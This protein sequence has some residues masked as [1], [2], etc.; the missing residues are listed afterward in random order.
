MIYYPKTYGT[1][2]G[3]NK[4]INLAYK[5][6]KEHTDKNVV[7]YKEILHNPYVIKELKKDNIICID[8]LEKINKDD[9]VIIRAHGETLDTFKYLEDNNI[10]YYDATCINVK[11]VHDIVKEKYNENYKIIIVG[12]K[13]H[14]EVIGTASRCNNEAIIIETE[15]DYK[16]INKDDNYF[17][18]CQTT[19]GYETV[20]SLLNYLNINNIKYEHKNTICPHQKLIQSSSVSLSDQMD[21]MFIIGGKHSSN[22]RELYNQCKKICAKSYH[23]D[24]INEFYEIIKKEDLSYTTKIGITAGGSTPKNQIQEFEGL[25]EF[26]IYYKNKTKEL[27]KELT[28]YNKT[29]INE[30]DNKIIKEAINKFINMNS[31]GKFL[32]GCLIDLG[33]KL[34][35]ND[36]YANHLAIAYETFQTSI[37]V[38]DDIIDNAPLRRGKQTIHESYKEEFN[39]FNH[40][41]NIHNNL[42]LCIGDIGFFFTNDLIIKKY[43][44]D[45]NFIKLFNYYN[46][47]VINTI[48]GEILDVYLPFKEKYDKTNKITENDILKIYKLKTSHYSIVGPFILGMI[49]SNSSAKLIKEMEQILEN[50]GI[51]FQI[52]DDILGIFSSKEIL[53]KSVYSDIEEFKQT[54]LYSYIKINKPEYLDKLLEYYGKENICEEDAKCV[55]NIIIESGS[56]DYANNLMNNL[57]IDSKDKINNLDITPHIK[58]ILLGLITYLEIREK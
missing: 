3:A 12:K 21:I 47:I 56:L 26:A 50:I 34:N 17:V 28:K 25:L 41:E 54:I 38:H 22:T 36:D 4:A 20:S 23:V 13:T 48:K 42:S 51:A 7:I 46:Q 44:N 14:P 31:N 30:N 8:D 29:L 6:K 18:V 53:G 45:K 39:N 16:Q 19:I 33:Y 15:D 37:L 10:E 9:I 40:N 49:L 35:K 55:Q 27:N 43:K 24:D 58:N 1:C 32:R 11:K 5:L 57:F 2:S 52:K